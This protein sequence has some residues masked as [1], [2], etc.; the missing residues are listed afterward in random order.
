MVRVDDRPV[1]RVATRPA[2]AAPG[3]TSRR[4]NVPDLRVASTPNAHRE[5][6]ARDAGAR[7]I[8]IAYGARSNGH[9]ARS[10]RAQT[11]RSTATTAS[12]LNG[13]VGGVH[14]DSAR[15]R[16]AR[17]RSRMHSRSR[18]RNARP[19]MRRRPRHPGTPH[20]RRTPL[21]TRDPHP[22]NRS[23]ASP[24]RP[25]PTDPPP[26]RLR[27]QPPLPHP[28]QLPHPTH[29]SNR[30]HPGRRRRLRAGAG[31]CRAGGVD[32]RRPAG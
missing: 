14:R 6:R 30:R 12:P 9:P 18:T 13:R 22:S 23:D 17:R 21:T 11:I 25:V 31:C 5:P 8:R 20:P 16:G 4:P 26:S 24:A 3:P 32:A 29:W 1:T 15:R 28:T 2:R 10:T 7:R 27:G 19:V